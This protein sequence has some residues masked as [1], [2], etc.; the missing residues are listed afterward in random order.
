MLLGVAAEVQSQ[1]LAARED[2]LLGCGGEGEQQEGTRIRVLCGADRDGGQG[3]WCSDYCREQVVVV[4]AA[5]KQGR[6]LV[7]AAVPRAARGI[8]QRWLV[9]AKLREEVLTAGCTVLHQL[10]IANMYDQRPWVIA[11]D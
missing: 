2:N 10:G 9:A 4:V 7:A 3:R 1:R 8:W 11:G 6:G 5:R